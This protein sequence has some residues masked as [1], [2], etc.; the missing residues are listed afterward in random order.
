MYSGNTK[1]QIEF[2][3]L[4]HQKWKQINETS[5]IAEV[6][7]LALY[8]TSEILG[9]QKSILFVHDDDTGLFKVE[10]HRGYSDSE[11]QRLSIVNLLLSGE[12]IEYL[13]IY[14]DK[15][16][17]TPEE[18]SH[19]V[20]KFLKLLGIEEAI[21][22]LFGGNIDVP[23]GMIVVGNCHAVNRVS[24][25]DPIIQIP[26]N[27]LVSF[28]SNSIN[29]IVFYRA[30]KKEKKSLQYNIELRTK[31]LLEAK[32]RAET[33]TKAKSVFL[34]NMSHEIRTPMNGIIGMTQL[35]LQATVDGKLH[36]YLKKID[37]SAQNLLQ[38]INDILD[39]SKI[40]AGKLQ[41][42]K[43]DFDLFQMVENV[44]SLI[45]IK[46]SEKELEILVSYSPSIHQ[47]Y[48]GDVLR[49]S[50]VLTNLLSNAVKFTRKG[51]ISVHVD[52]SHNKYIRFNVR[53]T[54]IGL[55]QKQQSK[56]FHSFSQADSSTTRKYGGT[57]L[58][59]SISKQLVELMNGRIWVRS[60]EGQG[61]I[62]SFEIELDECP[63]R[64]ERYQFFK[65]KKVLIVDDNPTC[66][67]ILYNLLNLFGIDTY[68]ALDGHDAFN[69]ICADPTTFD[70]I[71]MDWN[72]PDIDGI[73]T[74]RRINQACSFEKPPT[75][76]M[77]SAYRQEAIVHAAKEVGIEIFLQKPINPSVLNDILSGM[78]LEEF[79]AVITA[80]HGKVSSK[81]RLKTLKDSVILLVEDN[82]IN[83][84]IMLGILEESGIIIDIANNGFEAVQMFQK[85]NY[86]LI[87]M[88][89]QMPLLDGYEATKTIREY[90]IHIPIIALTANAMKED[91]EQTKA[92]GM[93]DHLSKPVNIEYLY[94][95]LLTYI[96]PKHSSEFIDFADIQTQDISDNLQI[97]IIN[98]TKGL[99][100]MAGNKKL[101][102]KILGDFVSHY[103]NIH[104][105]PN[106]SD[107]HVLLH[108][109]KGLSANIGAM[110]LNYAL[111][112]CEKDINHSTCN[113]VNLCLQEVLDAIRIN[114]HFPLLE[115][116]DVS[117]KIPLCETKYHSLLISLR[118]GAR[119]RSSMQCKKIIETLE[120]LHLTE[121]Q[122]K[123][124]KQMKNWIEK[125]QYSN[126]I[127]AI[128][129]FISSK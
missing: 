59:L 61:S 48:C 12:I 104:C 31:E 56:L 9:F 6:F 68:M 24:V 66:R 88:D 34:A 54:G 81:H 14:S 107:I 51:E 8:F 77:V 95:I 64:Q 73:E 87:L 47:Y 7:D 91:I 4:L 30:W 36:N 37:I 57:G 120:E 25:A 11:S 22:I 117:T 112:E 55:S 60:T 83:Q 116:S 16:V 26:L 99:S 29:T 86:E 21:L 76:I 105:D 129:H 44:I 49:I 3:A 102:R 113:N 28:L 111:T 109:L 53:D 122:I 98:F 38:I 50:Q 13:R 106:A 119:K 18:P 103:S 23:Y 78:F 20:D 32:E 89:I 46:A 33:A 70:L 85:N 15:I 128:A 62:F 75:V 94:E 72:M 90:D 126:I 2:Y 65:N 82:K 19:L 10:F 45:E 110:K 71:L 17:H 84:E 69:Q 63:Q 42:E 52:K 121:T 100:H 27:N 67:E 108:T 124:L 39:I 115:D 80:H 96:V 118:D 79:K 101:Y 5:E 74:M 43:N 123:S 97:D 58:G 125:R 114:T 127:D 92:A 40:E 41:I 35:A 1:C 93:N